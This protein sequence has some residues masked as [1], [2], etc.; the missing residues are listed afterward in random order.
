MQNYPLCYLRVLGLWDIKFKKTTSNKLF[1][2]KL[3]LHKCT[4]QSLP[5]REIL[6]KKSIEMDNLNVSVY[7]FTR[8]CRQ[9]QN[10]L[11]GFPPKLKGLKDLSKLLDPLPRFKVPEKLTE[12]PDYP[13]D[14]VSRVANNFD[15]FFGSK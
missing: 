14:A 2:E 5:L 11:Q 10:D 4:V 12:S 7:T 3:H 8:L 9:N 6:S 15:E 1:L 13:Y